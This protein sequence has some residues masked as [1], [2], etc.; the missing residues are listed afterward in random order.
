[1]KSQ[2][3]KELI[4]ACKNGERSGLELRFYSGYKGSETPRS[5]RIGGKELQIEEVLWRK[6]GYDRKS[7]KTYEDFK[8]RLK[9]QTVRITVYDTGEWAISFPE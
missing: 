5:I 4:E 9:G 8:C 3:M 7:A 1:M 2:R 6:R